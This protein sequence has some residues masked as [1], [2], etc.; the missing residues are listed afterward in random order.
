[1]TKLIPFKKFIVEYEITNGIIPSSKK[2]DNIDHD[3]FKKH[4]LG[5][6]DGHRVVHYKSK[7]KGSHY[8]FVTDSH[9]S[10]VGHIEHKPTKTA[11]HGRLAISNITK[12]KDSHYSMG[13]VLHHLIKH[14][15]SLESDDTNTESGAHRM[16]QNF[17]KRPDITTHIE[18][19]HG[20]VVPHTGDITSHENQKK[21]SGKFEEPHFWNVNRHKLVFGKK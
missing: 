17:S 9:G 13:N 14:G 1:M 5:V 6:V 20:E 19:G 3:E 21:Y 4:E 7:S 2:E 10:T 11:K 16:L 8:T 15:H 12:D 18:D